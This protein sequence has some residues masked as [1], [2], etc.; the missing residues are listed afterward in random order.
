MEKAGLLARPLDKSH[1]DS[2]STSVVKIRVEINQ[3][4]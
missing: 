4:D 1:S 3:A 2:A